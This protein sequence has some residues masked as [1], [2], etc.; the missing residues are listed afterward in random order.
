MALNAITNINLDLKAPNAV[1]VYANQYDST[2]AIVAQLLNNGEAWSV[3]SGAYAT[4]S[5]Q[6]TDSIG[7]YYDTTFYGE[8]AVTI[9]SNRSII[10][11]ILD[12]QVMTTKGRVNIQVNFIQNKRRLSTFSFILNVQASPITIENASSKWFVNLLATSGILVD[13]TLSKSGSAADALVTGEKV[14][15]KVNKPTTSPNGTAGQVLRTN[16]DG[17]TTWATAASPTDGQVAEAVTSWLDEHPEAT[18]TVADGSI[19]KEKLST[20]LNNEIDNLGNKIDNLS[21]GLS[22]KKILL[23][24]DSYNNGVGGTSGRGWGYYFQQ[25]TGCDATIVHQNGGGFAI[26]GNSNATYPNKTFSQ[27]VEQITGEFDIIIAQSGW[28]DAGQATEASIQTNVAAFLTAAKTKW[29]NAKIYVIPTNNGTDTTYK[30]ANK[31]KAIAN[32]ALE[33]NTISSI[34]SAY[35]LIGKN[36]AATDGIHLTDAGYKLLA[37]YIVDYV[38]G[39]DGVIT[40]TNYYNVEAADRISPATITI[41][42]YVRCYFNNSLCTISFDV[43]LTQTETSWVTLVQNLPIPRDYLMVTITNWADTFQRAIRVEI[44]PDGILRLRYGQAG[45][46]RI[47][48]TYPL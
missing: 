15:S 40:S 34:Y 5:Y 43:T 46:Y 19:T 26:A 2:G 9:G 20:D 39:W 45:N 28:N 11:I 10:T 27:C 18:T 12:P 32:A 47:L 29:K 38:L 41:G 36:V 25:F 13:P 44:A 22:S 1:V 48:L 37:H 31:L 42:T 14:N 23:I 17:T 8:T 16:G 30:K 35:W 6:K 7:G 3:P 24:G 4:I 21:A 33:N